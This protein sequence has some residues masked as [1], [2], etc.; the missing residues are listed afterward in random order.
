MLLCN[1]NWLFSFLLQT[2]DQLRQHLIAL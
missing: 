1:P 2:M